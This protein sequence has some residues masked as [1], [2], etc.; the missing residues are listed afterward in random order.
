MNV[1]YASTWD[2]RCGVAEYSHSLVPELEK[3]VKVEVVSLDPGQINTPARLAA[4][5]NQ[6]DVAHIQHQ[7]PFFGGMAFYRNWFRRAVSK[8]EVPLV[9]TVHELDLGNGNPAVI[10]LYKRYFNKALFEPA[11]IYRFIVHSEDFRNKMTLVGVDP[12]DVSVIPEGVPKV[13]RVRISMQNAKIL[14]NVSNRKVITIFGFVVKRKGYELALKALKSL[15]E[16]VVLIIAGGPHPDDKTGYFDDL[17]ESIAAM[18][19]QNRVIIT[20]YLENHEVATIMAATDLVIAPFTSMSNSGSILRSIA[21]RK[22]ILASDLPWCHE[23][24][25]RCK[26]VSLFRAGD[27]NDLAR[28]IGE[29]LKDRRILT[30]ASALCREYSEEWSVAK[31]A[32]AT[33]EVYNEVVEQ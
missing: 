18:G 10:R 1:V 13:N 25:A 8:V 5:L 3:Y 7:Y 9:V 19:I 22:P 12:S 26:G 2:C 29:M 21:Y 28:S 16:D 31:A 6:G 15:P 32:E 4:R 14:W 23:L 20:D 17:Q 11:E 33:V 30:A 27:A 24:N